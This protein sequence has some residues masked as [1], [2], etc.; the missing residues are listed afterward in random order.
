MPFAE[1]RYLDEII[2]RL[3]V[4]RIELTSNNSL[5]R[6]N[7]NKSAEDFFCGLINLIYDWN[8]I[9]ANHIIEDTPGIDLIDSENCI[10]IQV[11][12]SADHHKIQTS[13]DKLINY[14]PK[15]KNCHFYMMVITEKQK[16]Y[17]KPF[18]I[19][20]N[21]QF[22]KEK[23]IWD[24]DD[25]LIQ[26]KKLPTEKKQQIYEYINME[27][28]KLFYSLEPDQGGN[29][30]SLSREELEKNPYLFICY[31]HQ[32]RSKVFPILSKFKEAGIRYWY[33]DNLE[34]GVHYAE[35][36]EEAIDYCR[37]AI[38]FL[39]NSAVESEWCRNEILDCL[40][41]K[42]GNVFPV[43]IEQVKLKY[44]LRIQLNNIE[45]YDLS[46]ETTQS[47]SIDQLI[48]DLRNVVPEVF[49]S[50]KKE[51]NEPK[52]YKPDQVSELYQRR[53]PN[54]S[55]SLTKYFTPYNTGYNRS[56]EFFLKNIFPLLSTDYNEGTE[57][58][59]FYKDIVGGKSTIYVDQFE[60]EKRLWKEM[61]TS[62]WESTKYLVGAIG[63]GKTTLIRNVFKIFGRKAVITENNLI[64]YPAF[65]D[66]ENVS[67]NNLESCIE[68]IEKEF[69]YSI[70]YACALL[71]ECKSVIEWHIN[72]Y[73]NTDFYEKFYRFIYH[74]Y[75]DHSFLIDD[76]YEFVHS[77]T[78]ENIYKKI[79]TRIKNQKAM[80]YAMIL[81]KY[82]VMQ[83]NLNSKEPLQNIVL[84]LDNLD[85]A[86]IL[87][88]EQIFMFVSI[89]ER[90]ICRRIRTDISNTKLL[91]SLRNNSFRIQKSIIFQKENA[92]RE[93]PKNIPIILKDEI[94]SISKIITKRIEYFLKHEEMI[95]NIE[96]KKKWVNAI[97]LLHYILATSAGEYDDMLLNLTNC[98][99]RASMD[100]VKRI[101]TNKRFIGSDSILND[102]IDSAFN[103]S[104]IE[105]RLNVETKNR[106][107]PNK[108]E[109][110]YSLVYGEKDIYF[111]KGDY[112]LSNILQ[113]KN[114][115]GFSAEI[116]GPYII[117]Y[118]IVKKLISDSEISVRFEKV[119]VIIKNILSVFNWSD[120]LDRE[121]CYTTIKNVIEYYYVSG[122]LSESIVKPRSNTE[123]LKS[124][125]RQY[126]DE[127]NVFLSKRGKQ[128]YA[129]LKTNSLILE[130]YRDDIETSLP[131]NN[132]P[133]LK[134][135]QRDC[136][137]YCIEYVN[138]IQLREL[139]L[140]YLIANGNDYVNSFGEETLA[141]HLL[142]GIR[143]TIIS[144]YKAN[145]SE[146]AEIVTIYNDVV[147]R[148][149]DTLKKINNIFSIALAFA[150]AII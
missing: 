32:D 40:Q 135:S 31:C 95:S 138:S 37:G 70:E 2:Y 75:G 130:A 92:Y 120:N 96:D 84:I 20:N 99:L 86:Y 16:N 39:T 139:E 148:V 146:K 147:D 52:R 46:V 136:L 83:F 69:A 47:N 132:L 51:R 88:P 93:T 150:I 78:D 85:F 66:L 54:D 94:P 42:K 11:S 76:D 26:I 134:M 103:C 79:I 59:L 24:V 142:E 65:H 89:I 119:D 108:K 109:I 15:M 145:T 101:L 127:I 77:L 50:H 68:Q 19:N 81:L 6:F 10:A 13:L 14:Y 7:S 57:F 133:T 115:S 3:S 131:N 140:L 38:I 30:I 90:C 144:Y 28:G 125:S 129:M 107:F 141:V 1:D 60:L 29:Q 82:H 43:Y 112:Y 72:L 23:D 9:N 111:S 18:F 55:F 35:K 104:T 44:G 128:L 21:V 113:N 61:I 149:N 102:N 97:E 114:K 105:L 118:M 33:D 126:S 80:D 98:N 87:C 110:F 64:I 4:L 48:K 25:L 123:I 67:Y 36:I 27:C 22:N 63:V 106:Y 17:Q 143:R 91:V 74:N 62:S 117:K 41:E 137:N 71:S 8:L 121:Q 73:Q 53:A 5:K 122:V 45:Y 12:A 100:L 49:S 34:L 116:W 56:S 124:L 58:A